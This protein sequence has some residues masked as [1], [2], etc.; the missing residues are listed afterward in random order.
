V[1]VNF[2]M[3][4]DGKIA[5]PARKQTRISD[6][7]DLRRVHQ[8]RATCDA[9]LV[10]VGTVLADD[11]KL[12][13]KPEYATGRNPLRVVLDSE[14][15]TPEGAHVLNRDAPTLIV[16][17]ADCAKTFPNAEVARFGQDAV[18][19]S[20][21]LEFL[22]GKGVRRLLVEGGSETIWSFLHARLADEVKVF[23]G[24]MVIGGRTSPTPAGG[25][26]AQRLE[27]I[28]PLKLESAKPLGSGVLLEYAVVR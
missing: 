19:L 20:A 5:L 2:A 23:V 11:P 28:V 27:E 10:G 14:G 7:E 4:V 22:G 12:T 26:G 6:E 21:L 1:T 8:L 24:S 3:S 16:T 15:R 18:D 17:T 25:A 13:V 9:V